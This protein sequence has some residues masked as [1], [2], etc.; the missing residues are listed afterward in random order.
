MSNTNMGTWLWPILIRATEN[1]IHDC[2]RIWDGHPLVRIPSFG[3][4]VHFLGEGTYRTKQS[5]IHMYGGKNLQSCHLIYRWGGWVGGAIA[6][7]AL[8]KMKDVERLK[9]LLR[10]G[11]FYVEGV[12]DVAIPLVSTNLTLDDEHDK[13][14][15]FFFPRQQTPT[16]LAP[17]GMHSMYYHVPWTP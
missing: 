13:D 14:K 8:C 16:M 7:C 11:K 12:E 2:P 5:Y 15:V 6:S 9:M 1:A 3:N 10:W 4:Y 17:K